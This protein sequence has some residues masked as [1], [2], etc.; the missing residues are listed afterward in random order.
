MQFLSNL[1]TNLRLFPGVISIRFLF[2]LTF[3]FLSFRTDYVVSNMYAHGKLAG[4]VKEVEEEANPCVPRWLIARARF[5]Q[6]CAVSV[7]SPYGGADYSS[8]ISCIANPN[9]ME[10][11]VLPAASA[12]YVTFL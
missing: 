4:K 3:Y 12:S 8:S 7:P 10:T 11:P 1:Q 9:P 5:S 6:G 2:L